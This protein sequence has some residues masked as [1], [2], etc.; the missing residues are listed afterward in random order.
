MHGAG[1]LVLKV[2]TRWSAAGTTVAIDTVS[3]KGTGP[4]RLQRIGAHRCRRRKFASVNIGYPRARGFKGADLKDIRIHDCRHS[5]ASRALALG[6]SLPMIG[7]LLG[8]SGAQTT[9]RYAHLAGDWVGESAVRISDSIAADILRGI[10]EGNM[11]N[12]RQS[13]ST[14]TNDETMGAPAFP[15]PSW[16]RMARSA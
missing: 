9:E 14:A 5:F 10:R 15:A 2:P 6:V 3:A 4:L 12:S 16:R 7:R 1:D 8:H 11:H 13:V